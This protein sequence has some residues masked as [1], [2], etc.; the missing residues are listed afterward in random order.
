MFSTRGILNQHLIGDLSLSPMDPT[1]VAIR[2]TD[3]LR[4]SGVPS[5]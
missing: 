2:I 5:A 1:A 3:V 4:V